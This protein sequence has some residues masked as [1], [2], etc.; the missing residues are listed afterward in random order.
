MAQCVFERCDVIQ[1]TIKQFFAPY[2]LGGKAYF[3][4]R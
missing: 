1:N 2:R 3:L 4:Y